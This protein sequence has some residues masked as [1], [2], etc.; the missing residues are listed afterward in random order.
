MTV[1]TSN[2]VTCHLKKAERTFSS[3]IASADTSKNFPNA[4]EDFRNNLNASKDFPKFPKTLENFISEVI[5]LYLRPDQFNF[6]EHGSDQPCFCRKQK[7][8][9]NGPNIF[10]YM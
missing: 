7:K 9:K 5:G 10:I 3:P 1:K 6:R 4:F 8:I 2:A